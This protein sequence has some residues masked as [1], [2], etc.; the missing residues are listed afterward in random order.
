MRWLLYLL[1]FLALLVLAGFLFPREATT[2]RS[3][4][5]AQPPQVVFPYLNNFQNFNKWSPWYQIDPST[6]YTYT[7]NPEGKGAEMHWKSEDPN[8]G[9]GTQTIT[10]SEPYSRIAT[11]LDFGTQGKAKA[12]FTLKPQ[13]SGTNVTWSFSSDMGGSPIARWMGLMVSRMVG[14]SYA[15]GLDKL[16]ALVESEANAGAPAVDTRDA[17]PSEGSNIEPENVDPGMENEIIEG[18]DVESP[19]SS[20]DELGEPKQEI[21]P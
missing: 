5:I 11:D 14:E 6:E 1:I 4:Y 13:G 21:Q 16:K 10:V 3:V 12:E 19:D 9:N 2:E 20:G 8:V 18:D 7:G 15:E 17:L